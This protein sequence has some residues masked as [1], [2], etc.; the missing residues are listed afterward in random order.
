M[1]LNTRGLNRG[2]KQLEVKK[3][4][5]THQVAL[6]GLLE[7]KVKIPNLGNLYQNLCL[8]WCFT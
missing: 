2:K 6:F 1:V 8:G 4:M 3:F 7:T 5:S